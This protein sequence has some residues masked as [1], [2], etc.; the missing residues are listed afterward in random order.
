MKSYTIR[1]G[2][3]LRGSVAM[4][5]AKNAVLPMMAAC[6]MVRGDVILKNVPFLTDVEAMAGLLMALGVKVKREGDVMILNSDGAVYRDL[7]ESGIKAMR[8]SNLLWGPMLDRFGEAKLLLPG[9]C[10]IGSRPMDLHIRGMEGLGV[11]VAEEG[12]VIYSRG[13]KR[14]GAE[15]CLDLPSV[16]AT[17]NLVMAAVGAEG[18]TVIRNA[19]REPEVA[20]LC[21]FLVACG[22]SIGNIGGDT[23]VID[24]G[25][26]LRGGEYRVCPDRIV[27]GTVLLAAMMC[28][29]EVEATA[30]RPEDLDALLSKMSQCGVAV[31]R[32]C[33]AITVRSGGR[34][35]GADLKT[36]P[37]PG[38]PT[39]LQPQF[40]AAMAKAEGASLIRESIFEHRF[41]QV[42][43]LRKMGADILLDG[44]CALVRGKERLCGAEVEAFD[45]RCGAALVIAALAAEGESR[46]VGAEFVER[47]YSDVGALFGALGGEVF[48]E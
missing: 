34:Y 46:V 29:G 6:L 27:C 10:R 5:G 21:R 37:Y 42:S 31:E 39:D 26:V 22:G 48:S 3:A 44:G 32:S 30:V 25:R 4:E 41:S 19:A 45:L 1:G 14:K 43:E 23:L 28:G 35:R 8:A 36:M 11:M 38:F 20:D 24:G 16:G 40:M 15:I 18:R 2:K 13:E 9:G 47:G 33:D 7:P 12:G 17:E